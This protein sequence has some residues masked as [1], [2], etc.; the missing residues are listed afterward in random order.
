[1]ASIASHLIVNVFIIA[2]SSFMKIRFIVRVRLARRRYMK[3]RAI[4]QLEL[5]ATHQRRREWL[6][7]RRGYVEDQLKDH[8]IVLKR[9]FTQVV[10]VRTDTQTQAP[11]EMPQRSE[12]P[13]LS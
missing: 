1:M 7:Q 10:L 2:R 12:L 5:A 13:Y 6:E 8:Q 4:K 9:R 3:L 11:S